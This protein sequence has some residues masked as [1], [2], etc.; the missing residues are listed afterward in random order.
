MVDS[1]EVAGEEVSEDEVEV[2]D[3]EVQTST[4]NYI[5]FHDLVV[6]VVPEG[7]E[8]EDDIKLYKH[9]IMSTLTLVFYYKV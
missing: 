8:V 3:L 9:Y 5:P 1:D 2:A 7:S 4:H 6:Q